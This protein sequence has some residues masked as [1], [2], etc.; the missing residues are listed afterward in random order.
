MEVLMLLGV[1]EIRIFNGNKPTGRLYLLPPL[2][3][4]PPARHNDQESPLH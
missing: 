4:P 3:P 1:C 2:P